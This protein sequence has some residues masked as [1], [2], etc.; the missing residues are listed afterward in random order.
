MCAGQKSKTKRSLLWE[1]SVQK[2][3]KTEK[4]A[5]IGSV[6]TEKKKL[7]FTPNRHNMKSNAK[8]KSKPMGSPAPPTA[9]PT[10]HPTAPPTIPL[11]PCGYY[12]ELE[13]PK[14]KSRKFKGVHELTLE[15]VQERWLPK[16]APQHVE[17]GRLLIRGMQIIIPHC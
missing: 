11:P 1:S 10:A 6:K 3:V 9:L 8:S 7:L 16:L 15:A 2:I 5:L 4:M 13:Y 12:F 17:Y 14:L